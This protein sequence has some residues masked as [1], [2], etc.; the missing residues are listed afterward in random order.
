MHWLRSPQ[1][2]LDML[3]AGS[4]LVAATVVLIVL[5]AA[6]YVLVNAFA[7]AG[8]L[9]VVVIIWE[10]AVDRP[11]RRTRLAGAV[12]ASSRRPGVIPLQTTPGQ[13]DWTERLPLPIG[14]VARKAPAVAA[15]LVLIAAALAINGLLAEVLN[16]DRGDDVYVLLR[17]G[18]AGDL[19]L[20][21]DRSQSLRVTL[22]GFR[23]WGDHPA[24]KKSWGAEVRIENIGTQEIASPAWKLRADGEEYEPRRTP[25]FTLLRG[26][27]RTEWIVFEIAMQA[28]P[29]WL[30][31]S[32]P[33]YPSVYF[34]IR[35]IYEDNVSRW[36]R[37]G[38]WD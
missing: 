14:V 29:E 22:L 19:R 27:A 38:A 4:A 1:T 34:A 7:V 37:A 20:Q 18:S 23:Q 28:S 6:L 15:T 17:P 16:P 21:E 33:D 8:F 25:N 13:A 10:L 30:R 35:S 12:V 3:L 9:L 32:R 11:R 36:D 5:M 31:A 2:P 24:S 26:E